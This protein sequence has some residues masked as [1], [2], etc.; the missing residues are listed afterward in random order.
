MKSHHLGDGGEMVSIYQQHVKYLVATTC[1]DTPQYVSIEY[2]WSFVSFFSV[3]PSV[4]W[5]QCTFTNEAIRRWCTDLRCLLCTRGHVVIVRVAW[6]GQFDA[7]TRRKLW[8]LYDNQCGNIAVTNRQRILLII[9]CDWRNE[10]HYSSQHTVEGVII[11]YPNNYSWKMFW[12]TLR[13]FT[14]WS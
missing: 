6:G 12:R 1:P 10:E 5:R 3:A 13:D 4:L 11:D 8:Q 9:H 2:W 14:T 7:M